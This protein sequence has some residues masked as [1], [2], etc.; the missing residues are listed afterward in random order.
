MTGDTIHILSNKQ[1]EKL[2][3]L[4]V[5]NNAFL[6]QI[7]SSGY[8]QVK[9]ERLI[10]LFTNNQLDTVNIIK[11]TEAIYFFRDDAGELIGIDNTTSSSIQMYLENQQITGIRFIKK[12]PGKIYP[13]SE[14]PENARILPGFNW[15]GEERLF[16]VE[17]LF[18]GKPKPVLPKIRGIPL[19]EDEGTFF[20]EIPEEE[21]LLPDISKLKPEDLQNRKDDPKPM[22]RPKSDSLQQ[23][24]PP[25]PGPLNQKK[26]DQ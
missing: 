11:N 16:T 22:T 14:F 15:R 3:T 8:N 9:G 6:I 23:K 26:K 4:K 1:T 21:L 24:K 5:F 7:D 2:D 18:N 20:E 19:P 10:G 13:P 25:E 12:V 17:D